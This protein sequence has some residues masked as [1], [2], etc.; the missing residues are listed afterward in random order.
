MSPARQ[1]ILRRARIQKCLDTL[2]PAGYNIDESNEA[3]TI[4]DLG[5]RDSAT[6]RDGNKKVKIV[7]YNRW[8]SIVISY[9]FLIESPGELLPNRT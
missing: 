8:L 7:N 4:G 6:V 9:Y 5:N 2:T 1:V 3:F